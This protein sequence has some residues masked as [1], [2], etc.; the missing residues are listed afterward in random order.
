VEQQAA[1]APGWARRQA[2]W[3]TWGDGSGGGTP[4]P[5]RSWQGQYY[6]ITVSWWRGAVAKNQWIPQAIKCYPS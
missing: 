5:V 1:A 6:G 3:A 4:T 2:P